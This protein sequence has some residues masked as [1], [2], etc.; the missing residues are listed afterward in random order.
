MKVPLIPI[1]A[2]HAISPDFVCLPKGK[3]S[4]NSQFDHLY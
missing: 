1:R 2:A 4:C 3:L